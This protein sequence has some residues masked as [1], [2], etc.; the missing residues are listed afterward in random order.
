MD[1]FGILVYTN[2]E[3]VCTAYPY[4]RQVYIVLV[5]KNN[6]GNQKKNI[7]TMEL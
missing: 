1:Y 5:L 6:M 4:K 2:T 3:S 7:K